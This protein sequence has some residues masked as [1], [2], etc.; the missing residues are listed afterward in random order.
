METD[1]K[2]LVDLVKSAT[3]ARPEEIF[4]KPEQ[5][6]ELLAA[7]RKLTLKLEDPHEAIVRMIFQVKLLPGQ[8]DCNEVDD[9]AAEFNV[10]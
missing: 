8:I 5:R 2:K 10:L 9:C 1:G 3:D 4:K 7:L 6:K